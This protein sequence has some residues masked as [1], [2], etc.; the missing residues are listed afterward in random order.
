MIKR[1]EEMV[2]ETRSQMRGGQGEVQIIHLFKPD[3]FRGKARLY[4]RVIL[5]PGSSI[6][7]HEHVGE[8][9]IYTV[10]RGEAVLTDS[11]LESEKIMRPGD[12]SLT[13]SGESHAIRNDGAETLEIMA[14]VLLND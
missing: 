11:T 13:L 6:G 1:V 8:E 7:M 12:A 5:E 2:Q 3:E 10:I 14:L 9:E 4:A